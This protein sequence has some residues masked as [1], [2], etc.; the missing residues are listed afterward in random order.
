MRVP[1]KY[2][3]PVFIA[4][5]HEKLYQAK[6]LA[7][8]DFREYLKRLM[9]VIA[10]TY[11]RPEIS[12]AMDMAEPLALDITVGIPCG[13]IVNELVSN[14]YKYGFPEGRKGMIRLGIRK[15]SDGDNVLSVEDNGIGFPQAVDFRN[16]AASLGLRIVTVLTSQIHG[17]IELS[18]RAGTK[19]SITFPG[20][21]KDKGTDNG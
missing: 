5:I 3:V 18:R 6:E 10:D 20:T 4:L 19:F 11:N 8:I 13:L 7:S 21:S 1:R 14:S 12:L 2:A 15:N 17:T 16:P 9:A